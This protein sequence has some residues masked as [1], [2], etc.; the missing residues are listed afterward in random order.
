MVRELYPCTLAVPIDETR[1]GLPGQ[2]QVRFLVV[3]RN[4]LMMVS[5]VFALSV[6]NSLARVGVLRTRKYVRIIVDRATRRRGYPS[7]HTTQY[8]SCVLRQQS[9]D[10]PIHDH[11]GRVADAK[12]AFSNAVLGNLYRL[13]GLSQVVPR[14]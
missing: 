7:L 1:T 6:E 10:T 11:P 14:W 5:Y 8:T 9:S 4:T 13:L 12:A 3:T 2:A